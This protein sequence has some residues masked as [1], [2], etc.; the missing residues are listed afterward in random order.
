MESLV[1]DIPAGDG[2]NQNLFFTVYS[3]KDHP[4]SILAI[5]CR[6]GTEIINNG[7]KDFVSYLRVGV[8]FYPFT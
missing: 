3:S 6:K 5:D 1:G 2:K 4:F 8:I 7:K